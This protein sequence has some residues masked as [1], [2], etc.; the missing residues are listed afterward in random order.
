MCTTFD[1]DVVVAPRTPSSIR[2][3]D[4]ET[5]LVGA[6]SEYLAQQTGATGGTAA[7]IRFLLKRAKPPDSLGT[8]QSRIRRAYTDLY[9]TDQ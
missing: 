1:Y 9:G 8:V 5:E 7:V 6:W 2:L 3:S 4:A